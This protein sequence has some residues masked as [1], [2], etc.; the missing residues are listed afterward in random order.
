VVLSHPN[1]AQCVVFGVSSRK[2]ERAENVVACIARRAPVSEQELR[3][4]VLARLPAW[5]V[6]RSWWFVAEIKANHRG[7]IV[8]HELRKKYLD[9]QSAS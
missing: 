4:F 9:E 1:I 6:P 5:Q 8:R 3:T 7:K 2:L